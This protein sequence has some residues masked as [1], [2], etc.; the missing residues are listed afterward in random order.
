MGEKSKQDLL[1]V[2]TER[3]SVGLSRDG[4]KI[5]NRKF[6]N[7]DVVQPIC[8]VN[9]FRYGFLPERSMDIQIFFRN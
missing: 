7:F 4:V 3:E 2:F 9:P 1:G 5:K 8:N 6:I